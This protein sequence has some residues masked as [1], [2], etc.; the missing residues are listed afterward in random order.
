MKEG[1]AFE[2]C[3]TFTGTCQF[4]LRAK[5]WSIKCNG[6]CTDADC[7]QAETGEPPAPER[8]ENANASRDTLLYKT[9]VTGLSFDLLFGDGS[10]PAAAAQRKADLDS[11]F[12]PVFAKAAG[13]EG[14]LDQVTMIYAEGSLLVTAQIEA[15]EG[16]MLDNQK[17]ELPSSDDVLNA[18]KSVPNIEEAVIPGM[19]LEAAAPIGVRYP[20]EGSDSTAREAITPP[21]TTT[22]TTTAAPTPPPPTPPAPTPAPTR[23]PP[24]TPPPR[25]PSPPPPP[26]PPPP[27][28]APAVT[29]VESQ[30]ENN[31]R[32]SSAHKSVVGWRLVP[33]CISIVIFSSIN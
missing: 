5:P 29:T 12:K 3:L 24:P 33:F 31:T 8:P 17:T 9:K 20:P 25:V 26:P 6:D 2:T 18:V 21:T 7:C 27:P 23:P 4:G 28:R 19:E 22:T 11:Q 32:T 14:Q 30:E 13:L 16:M 15:P 1:V 10:D